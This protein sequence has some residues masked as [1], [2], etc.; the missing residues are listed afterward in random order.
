M[1]LASVPPAEIRT[2]D[3]VRAVWDSGLY[4]ENESGTS[5]YWLDDDTILVSANRGPKPLTPEA[6]RAR[7]DWLYLWR[8]GDKPKPYSADP[9]TAAQSYCAAR[10]EISYLANKINPRTN[11]SSQV[12]LLGP[13][14]QEHDA[15]R[16]NPLLPGAAEVRFEIERTDCELYVDPAMAG[17]RYITDSDHR[18]YI[19]GLHTKEPALM[20]ADGSNRISLP[21]TENVGP[22]SVLYRNFEKKF[23]LWNNFPSGSPINQFEVWRETNCWPFWR[24]D[25]QTALT[26]RF[27]IPFGP[28]PS[29]AEG[30]HVAEIELVSTKAGLFFAVIPPGDKDERIRRIGGFYRLGD[31]AISR[32]FGGDVLRAAVSPN[33]CRIA[34]L[35]VPSLEAYGPDSPIPSTIKAIDVC[36]LGSD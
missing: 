33:G 35:H 25:P 1:N 17:K 5:I 2:G 28:W 32:L 3:V 7:E 36:S 15:Q 27:C 18:F 4:R 19:E 34:F 12:R 31:G 16:W 26:E 9:H 21:I 22:L 29:A 8:L 24:V 14:G 13:P 30:G 20:H 6:M 10:G 11:L 23:Y